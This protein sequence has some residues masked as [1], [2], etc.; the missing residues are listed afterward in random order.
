M[1]I[2]LSVDYHVFVLSRVREGIRNGLP[3]ERAVEFGIRETASVVKTVRN[4]IA[5]GML[6]TVGAALD[7]PEIC[8]DPAFPLNK[9]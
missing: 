5:Y 9:D 2:G 3:Y 1:L 7:I 6:L 4:F 8:G